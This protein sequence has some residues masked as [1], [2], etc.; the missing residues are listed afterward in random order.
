MAVG[1]I[2]EADQAEAIVAS[3]QADL[4]AIARGLIYDPRWRMAR[5]GPAGRHGDGA[6][7]ILARD[8]ARAEGALRRDHVRRAVSA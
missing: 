7:A 6:A 1:L 5:R 2:T 4:V 8:A 3:G